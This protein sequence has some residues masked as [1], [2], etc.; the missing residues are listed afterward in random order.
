MSGAIPAW[1][2]V[3]PALSDEIGIPANLL[4]RHIELDGEWLHVRYLGYVV[5]LIAAEGGPPD[6]R[7]LFLTRPRLGPKIARHISCAGLEIPARRQRWSVFQVS[8]W[9]KSTPDLVLRW[10]VRPDRSEIMEL[11]GNLL[12]HSA[13]D[14]ARTLKP[15]ELLRRRVFRQGHPTGATFVDP[16]DVRQRFDDAVAAV[17]R[18]RVRMWKK[19]VALYMDGIHPKTL[20]RYI[21]NYRLPWPP[22]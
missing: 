13:A 3:S 22:P 5:E 9:H 17:R 20:K 12:P 6:A 15:R 10:R 16:E 19:N 14:V 7:S 18:D 2:S 11:L 8:V 21:T 4:A 1:R